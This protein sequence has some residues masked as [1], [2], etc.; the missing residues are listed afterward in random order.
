VGKSYGTEVW[1]DSLHRDVIVCCTTAERACQYL[2]GKFL[3]V[4][5][6]GH[7]ITWEE[8]KIAFRE[9]YV[10]EGVLHMKQEEFIQLKQGEIL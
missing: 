7:Q 4:Q 10:P 8:F 1:V 9:N 3:A 2:V 6:D 5:P